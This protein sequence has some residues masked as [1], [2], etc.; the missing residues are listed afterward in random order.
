[1]SRSATDRDPHPENA[2]RREAVIRMYD[3]DHSFAD[4]AKAT[5]FTV[6]GAAKI[7]AKAREAGDPRAKLRRITQAHRQTLKA[8]TVR[9]ASDRGQMP[10]RLLVDLGAD[11]G[12]G[13]IA[14][15]WDDGGRW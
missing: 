1:M 8:K 12:L 4:I 6:R 9:W 3:A 15:D 11:H 7:V 13:G 10:G 14:S 2:E 5:G